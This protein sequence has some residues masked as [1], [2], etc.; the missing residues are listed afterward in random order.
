MIFYTY[1]LNTYSEQMG[2]HEDY[3][4]LTPGPHP[5]SFEEL[6]SAIA[7]EDSYEEERSRVRTTLFTHVD[8][9]ASKRIADALLNTP[10]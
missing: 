4:S 8:G 9:N 6:L 1:D 5:T 2:L 7:E 10:T 3:V